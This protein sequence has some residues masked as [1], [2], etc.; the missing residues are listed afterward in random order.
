MRIHPVELIEVK[1]LQLRYTGTG[2]ALTL[3]LLGAV[4][5]RSGSDAA[6]ASF[7][8]P[9]QKN[10]YQVNGCPI[11]SVNCIRVT[12]LTVPIINPLK[13]LEVLQPQQPDDFIITLPDVGE[14]DY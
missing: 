1:A 3:N 13:D 11:Q 2:T 9:R 6:A 10:N 5:G 7:I 12:T 14:K 8:Q 4:D